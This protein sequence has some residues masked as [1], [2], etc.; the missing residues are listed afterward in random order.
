MSF[1]ILHVFQHGATLAKEQGFIVCRA[2]SDAFFV[3]VVGADEEPD[4]GA[5]GFDAQG[6]VSVIDP[7][8]PVAPDLFEPKRGMLVVL[9][10][11]PVLFFGALP[12]FGTKAREPLP[13]FRRGRGIHR[14]DALA[15]ARIPQR[16]LGHRVKF[17]GKDGF[18]QVCI[19]PL[20]AQ[21]VEPFGEGAKILGWQGLD[22][23][24]D[25]RD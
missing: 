11:E 10:P 23:A 2:V 25:F 7:H 17:A 13:E 12:G 16:L 19:D 8:R 9:Q 14:G 18:L 15:L 5:V 22:G 21:F 1:H 6:A 4:E 24:F 20:F 3:F